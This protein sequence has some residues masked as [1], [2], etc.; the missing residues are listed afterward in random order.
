MKNQT[1]LRGNGHIKPTLN[2]LKI[3]KLFIVHSGSYHSLPIK[4]ELEN[5]GVGGI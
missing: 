2:A 1:I 3:K 4:N 5:A